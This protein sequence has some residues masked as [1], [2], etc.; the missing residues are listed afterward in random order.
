MKLW[1]IKKHL[2]CCSHSGTPCII[3]FS[4]LFGNKHYYELLKSPLLWIEPQDIYANAWLHSPLH[5]FLQICACFKLSTTSTALCLSS[6]CTIRI[7]VIILS[8]LF[9]K[10][11]SFYVKR[12][13]GNSLPIAASSAQQRV[14][15]CQAQPQSLVRNISEM[16]GK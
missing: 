1:L 3:Y 13:N 14:C 16:A 11:K 2:L 15:F 5:A 12:T 6:I 8:L 7:I 10:V 9:H 4:K